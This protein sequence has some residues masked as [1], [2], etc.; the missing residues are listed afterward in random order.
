MFVFDLGEPAF[1][2][3]IVHCLS[4]CLNPRSCSKFSWAVMLGGFHVLI[5]KFQIIQSRPSNESSTF[6]KVLSGLGNEH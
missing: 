5:L 6:F 1:P 3:G 2:T 4:D